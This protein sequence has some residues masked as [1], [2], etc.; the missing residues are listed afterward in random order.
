[1]NVASSLIHIA[2][3]NIWRHFNSVV[4]TESGRWGTFTSPRSSYSPLR[5]H[6]LHSGS[7]LKQFFL[8]PTPASWSPAL[9]LQSNTTSS[10]K[11]SQ[12]PQPA[13]ARLSPTCSPNFICMRLLLHFYSPSHW[14][15]IYLCALFLWASQE[16]HR[17]QS[18]SFS[19]RWSWVHQWPACVTLGIL[20]D[21]FKPY[22]FP[23][24][25]TG[26]VL[27]PTLVFGG[28]T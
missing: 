25:K 8:L 14:E 11:S 4:Y 24:L 19:F 22:H 28:A 5:I 10:G 21:L 6:A 2:A 27:F 13:A 18:N 3:R 23:G 9:Q 17:S 12:I 15:V 7:L 16:A 1:M 26:L 20:C